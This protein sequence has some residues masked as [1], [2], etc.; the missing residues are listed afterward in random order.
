MI[1]Y[2]KYN[3]LFFSRWAPIYDGLEILLHD[4][5]KEIIKEI[6]AS[7]KSVLDVA[8]GTGN[9]AMDLS[10]TADKVIGIDLSSEMLAQAVKKKINGNLSFILMDACKMEF[11]D[12]QFDV[13]T[14]TL[15]LHDMP[16]EIRTLVLEE[17]KRVLKK[18]GKLYILE[19][20]LPENDVL[21]NVSSTIINTLESRY[22]LGF[23]QSDFE[24]H[25]RSFGFQIVRKTSHL[26]HHLRFL[27]LSK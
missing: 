8:T 19:Y 12:E 26:F 11:N 1:D 21:A 5:R 23:V 18:D 9:L 10:E 25:L 2:K 13:V 17:V 14:I 7:N 22:Y 16:P 4:V 3:D 20:D 27:T 15:G 24:N 6:D